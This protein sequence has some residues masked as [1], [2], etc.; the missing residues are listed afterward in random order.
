MIKV[1][2]PIIYLCGIITTVITMFLVFM[3]TRYL[4]FDLLGFYVWIFPIGAFA[5]GMASG[6]GYMLSSRK[7]NVKRGKFFTVSVGIIA[8]VLYIFIHYLIYLTAG[9]DSSFLAF[10]SSTLDSA[11]NSSLTIGSSNRNT[12]DSVGYAG[13][14]F[15]ALEYIGFILGSVAIVLPEKESSICCEVC[16]KYYKRTEENFCYMP[17][18]NKV[19]INGLSDSE[20]ISQ[21]E[22]NTAI[23]RDELEKIREEV[24]GKTL[25]QTIEY[26]RSLAQKSSNRT[27][28]F[29]KFAIEN[30]PKCGDHDILIQLFLNIDENN[31]M[32][33]TNEP[34]ILNRRNK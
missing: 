24:K 8:F 9:G 14:A 27:N 3:I 21:I 34:P 10:I 20:K 6:T 7:L 29:M 25:K 12:I 33:T 22:A 30:C 32:T 15:L 4:N 1:K 13:Y 5:A 17:P 26:L 2:L 18:L 11:S 19:D 28:F 16:K 31:N 23:L